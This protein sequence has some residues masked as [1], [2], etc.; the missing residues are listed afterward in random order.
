MFLD[1]HFNFGGIH[2]RRRE[3]RHRRNSVGENT[4]WFEPT[5]ETHG[6]TADTAKSY[7]NCKYYEEHQCKLITKG[8]GGIQ[9]I[10]K[11]GAGTL[12]SYINTIYFIII[13]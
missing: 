5:F 9:K 10:E 11:G 13:L 8:G 4:D 2:F 12:S 7:L 1:N 6:V 3:T